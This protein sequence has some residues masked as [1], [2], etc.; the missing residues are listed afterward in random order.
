MEKAGY[1]VFPYVD[2]RNWHDPRSGLI[3]EVAPPML[4]QGY[5][6]LRNRPGLLIETHMLKPYNV[7]VSATYRAWSLH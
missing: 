5:T 3:S 7:R 6:A 4:S 2:F 1:P